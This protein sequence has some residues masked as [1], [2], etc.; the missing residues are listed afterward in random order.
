VLYVYVLDLLSTHEIQWPIFSYRCESD[1]TL[2]LPSS[3]FGNS[4][5]MFG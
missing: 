2:K 4:M 3:A 1:I 5:H